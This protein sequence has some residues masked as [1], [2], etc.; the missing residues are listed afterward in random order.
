MANEK[1]RDWPGLN[2]IV[3]EY[4]NGDTL[5]SRYE[6]GVPVYADRTYRLRVINDHPNRTMRFQQIH[7]YGN[8]REIRGYWS[9]KAESDTLSMVT[10]CVYTDPGAKWIPGFI[11]NWATKREIPTPLRPPLHGEQD[12]RG[13]GGRPEPPAGESARTNVND[14]RPEVSR[15]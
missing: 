15:R 11:V 7:G 6:L 13:Q 12:V 3:R 4:E 8:V 14:S 10:Y 2:K 9:V 5:I 1:D